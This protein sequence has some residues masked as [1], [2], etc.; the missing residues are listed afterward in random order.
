MEEQFLVGVVCMTYNQSAFIEDA[1]NG[2]TMQQTNFPYVCCVVDD[3]ST[4]GEP[5]VIRHYLEVH[6]ELSDKSVA[7]YE[8]TDDYILCYARHKTNKNCFFV[9]L[10]L[11][12]N[13]FGKKRK[14]PYYE[15]FLK[16]V[17]YQALCEG[18]D[19]WTDEK[20][21]QKQVDFLES[22]HDYTM[23]FHNAIE[24]FEYGNKK[25]R[26]FSNIRDRDY[27]GIEVFK[28]WTIPTAS[29]VFR[30]EVLYSTLYKRVLSNKVFMY[31]DG[32]LFITCA[33]LGRI[34]G[35]RDVM[36]VY[37]R[38]Q[39]S[40]THQSSYEKRKKS[41]YHCLEFYKVFGEKYRKWS[42]TLCCRE[43]MK[44]FLSSLFDKE[45]PIRYDFIRESLSISVILTIPALL[46]AIKKGLYKMIKYI[47]R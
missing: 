20:K 39:G 17:K 34:R 29:A 33:S 43:M 16:D 36:S 11:K 46:W 28:M 37:R 44:G 1:M 24:H 31:G 38:N 21:I 42:K 41:A 23:C 10:W 22:N 9:V 35:M 18:D 4:D 19:Y 13:H 32:P 6:F 14:A 25:D 45:S 2:F 12:Y 8:E 26:L 7:R 15:S 27:T 47:S 30:I 3:A 5:G 40:L